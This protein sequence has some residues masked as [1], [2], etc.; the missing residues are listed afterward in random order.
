MQVDG[1]YWQDGYA[2]VRGL[3]SSEVANAFLQTLKADMAE[4]AL[5]LQ[6]FSQSAPILDRP[7]IELYGHHYKPMIQFLWGLTPIVSS[8]AGREL[9]PTYNYFR[10]Y[11][12]DAICRVHSDR[13]SCE[14]SL[15]LTLGYSDDIAWP[16]EIDRGLIEAVEPIADSFEGA[17]VASLPMAAGD[18]VFYRGVEHRHGRTAPNPNRWSAHMFLHWVDR[19]SAQRRY[20]F[21]GHGPSRD[22]IDFQL[23]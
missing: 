5:P 18:A 9:L 10:I 15:S 12:K 3:I 1:D 2:L 13:P 16:L 21:D 20:A 23:P 8:L 11:P 7:A 19:G 4:Q 17:D 22:K 6:D 14:H